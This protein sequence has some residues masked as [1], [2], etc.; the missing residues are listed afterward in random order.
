[1]EDTDREK[2]VFNWGPCLR[3][4]VE[5]DICLRSSCACT[6]RYASAR[7]PIHMQNK[8]DKGGIITVSTKH[9]VIP[10]F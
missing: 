4:K 3:D 1:M 9:I 6:L 2:A 7:M 10:I 5:S 8:Q